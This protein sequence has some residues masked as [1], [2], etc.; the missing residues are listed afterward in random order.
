ML[1]RS[2]A[3]PRRAAPPL[4]T[5]ALDAPLS[6]TRS[7]PAPAS[8]TRPRVGHAPECR[9]R[10]VQEREKFFELTDEEQGEQ[11]ASDDLKAPPP[12]PAAPPPAPA[13]P[14]PQPA[15]PPPAP[16]APPAAKA[17]SSRAMSPNVRAL[18]QS[19]RGG[20]RQLILENGEVIDVP[21]VSDKDLN[22]IFE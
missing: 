6:H 18:R 11:E 17:S 9:C 7:R 21:E 1:R 5:A 12:Q 13:A 8:A 14:P 22:M 3:P 20:S 19:T 4:R 16:A 2:G 15:A 10:R